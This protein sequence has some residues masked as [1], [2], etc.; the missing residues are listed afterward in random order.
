MTF[1]P[2]AQMG[3][4]NGSACVLLDLLVRRSHAC[5]VFIAAAGDRH[6][7]SVHPLTAT[8]AAEIQ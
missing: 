2:P 1:T 3:V 8:A 7:G 6:R 4:Q 5:M